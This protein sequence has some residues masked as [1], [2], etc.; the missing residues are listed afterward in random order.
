[1]DEH[2][3]DSNGDEFDRFAT[4]EMIS[5]A[6]KGDSV[7]LIADDYFLDENK[8]MVFQKEGIEVLYGGEARRDQKKWAH[9]YKKF[10]DVVIVCRPYLM[11][12]Y[13]RLF[14]G[15]EV[16]LIGYDE[17][18]IPEKKRSYGSV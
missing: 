2:I 6:R 7:K 1:M 9:D 14:R 5:C 13:R 10:V 17:S 3:T 18:Q 15:T 4:E 11:R 8:A 16:R 12:K